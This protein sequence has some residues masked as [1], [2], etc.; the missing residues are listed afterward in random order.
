MSVETTVAPTPQ[1]RALSLRDRDRILSIAS[2]IGLLVV[3]EVAA[4]TGVIDTR[5]FP[6]PS[7]VLALLIEMLKSGELLTHTAASL[8]RL[9][10]GTL[11]G[12]VPALRRG[13]RSG[14]A[15]SSRRSAG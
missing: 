5:F 1:H 15:I 14:F 12:G 13:R 4:R 9:L 6:A 2:P 3:W 8:Q 11:I 10:W 7:S